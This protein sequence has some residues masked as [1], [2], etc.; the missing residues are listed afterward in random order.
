MHERMRAASRR[1]RTTVVVAASG[2]VAA[3]HTSAREPPPSWGASASSAVVP[4]PPSAPAP[5]SAGAPVAASR[6]DVSPEPVLVVSDPV[7]L[8]T[9]EAAG[10][11]FGTQV[12]GAP[13][14]STASLHEHPGFVTITDALASDLA[15]DRRLDSAAGVGMRFAHRQFDPRW[16][17]AKETRFDL[18][19][20]VNRL[21]R[22]PFSPGTCGEV[23]FIYRLAYR[24]DTKTGPVE[25]RLPMTA[26]VVYYAPE[27]PGGGCRDAARAWTAPRF[28][29]PEEEASWLLSS[30]GPLST[31][32]RAGW[33]PKSVEVNFQSVRWPSAVRP[34]MAGH[35]E[36][37]LRVFHRLDH[38]P[39][40]EPARLENTVDVA[41]L[42]RDRPLR[43]AL[44]DWVRKPD[45]LRAID[46]GTAVIPEQ[47]LAERAIS[48]SPHGL[49]RLANRPY[50][51]ALGDAAFHG[52][53][54]T[55]YRT[56]PTERGLLRRLDELTCPGCHQSRSLAGFH[57]LGV[58]P[59]AV[60]VDAVD[61]PMSPHFHAELTRRQR[62]ATALA[63]G[64]APDE[65]RPFAEH[66]EGDDREGAHCGLG[67]RAFGAWT[68]AA[69]LHCTRVSDPDVGECVPD[70]APTV[71]DACEP[72]TVSSNVDPHRDVARPAGRDDCATGLLCEASAVGFPSG[73]CSGS[74]DG[75]AATARCG[76]I[77]ILTEFNGCL[78]AGESFGRC[79]AAHT[80]PGALHACGFHDPCRDDYVCARS[81]AGGVCMPPYF[82]FQLRV[83]GHPI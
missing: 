31:V 37:V 73:M 22:R 54:L 8:G 50:L 36:Y 43:D 44:V 49:S 71:G 28:S 2:L 34:D 48:V 63:E 3:C 80:R 69:G 18:V 13:G 72:T 12:V 51:A 45:A 1:R 82:L 25:S 6:G 66:G 77:P 9:L 29:T 26:N 67:D 81:P 75:L 83:D 27:A 33:K 16:L 65:L 46:E 55:P 15:A 17:D 38:A 53:D 60:I 47:F 68:C 7:V 5:S 64:R 59:E 24:T 62:Y 52:V 35:A 57:L 14:K 41:R 74:C 58:A 32:R 76:G 30:A 39:F 4:S 19:F 56:I 61:V 78:A 42:R 10:L 21:D 20:V 40:F 11:D 23:R 79:I 70:G